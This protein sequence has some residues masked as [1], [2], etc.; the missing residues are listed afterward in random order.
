MPKRQILVLQTKTSP[1]NEFLKEFFQDTASE[2]SFFQDP[3]AVKT[4]LERQPHEIVFADPAL[5]SLPLSQALEVARQS[6]RDVIVFSA[7]AAQ[8]AARFKFDENFPV[9]PEMLEF[10]KKLLRCL[11]FPEKIHVLVVDDELEIG[12]MICDFLDRRVKPSFETEHAPNGAEGLRRILERAP[13]VMVLDIKMPLLDGREVYREMRKNGL[14]VPT[15]V[16]FDAVFG[17][18]LAEMRLYGKPAVI[19]KGAPQSALPE[20]LE[21]VKKM[22]FFC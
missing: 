3:A 12:R 6:G 5:V 8:P 13:D 10:Q 18:E 11:R 4:A 7:G 9:I 17:D 22:W 21:L 14:N 20:L 19:E 16:F 2:L 15:I 1:W